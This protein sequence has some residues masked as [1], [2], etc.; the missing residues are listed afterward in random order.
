MEN[1]KRNVDH[2]KPPRRWSGDSRPNSDSYMQYTIPPLVFSPNGRLVSQASRVGT[3]TEPATHDL[4][5]GQSR[6]AST[7]SLASTVVAD[8][9][10]TRGGNNES[11]R[12][13]NSSTD[14]LAAADP[15][16]FRPRRTSKDSISQLSLSSQNT[17]VG[18]ANDVEKQSRKWV[19]LHENPAPPSPPTPTIKKVV[20]GVGICSGLCFMVALFAISWLSIVFFIL[21]INSNLLQW[22]KMEMDIYVP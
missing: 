14:T 5:Q 2:N 9:N 6:T 12:Q 7:S 16:G 15:T 21:S 1:S 3:Q 4:Y 8:D 19:H 13:S 22:P 18:R 20:R 17:L 10:G 11:R